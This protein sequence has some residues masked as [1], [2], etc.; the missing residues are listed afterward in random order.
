MRIAIFGHSLFHLAVGLNQNPS[1]YVQL[2][3]DSNTFPVTLKDEVSLHTQSFVQ[4]IGPIT[5][6]DLLHPKSAEITERLSGFDVALV[7]DLGPIFAASASIEFIFIPGGSD[8]TEYPFPFRSKS[9]RSRGRQDIVSLT[10]AARLRPAIRSA[11]G[12]W[13]SGPFSPWVLAA[14]RLGL[15]LDRFL[16]RAFDTR[17]FS[18]V[19]DNS[20][21]IEDSESLTIFHP[22]RI[23]YRDRL[24]TLET[25]GCKRNDVLFLGFAKAI[26][27]G[28]DTRLILIERDGSP[29]Q[30]KAK[31]LLSSLGVAEKVEWLQPSDPAGYSWHETAKLY[32]SSDIVVSDFAGW[33]GMVNVE[34]AACSRPVIG[35]LE[36][37]AM[38]SMYPGGHPVVEADSA[39]AVFEAI[40]RLAD[41]E[42]RKQIGIA[43]RQWALKYHDLNVVARRCE[44]MLV[45]LGVPN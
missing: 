35:H 29:D 42:E 15:S 20:R 24:R 41:P 38:M 26:H 11:L 36:S 12:I 37:R 27:A 43:S 32:R 39:F 34:G 2:F 31:E 9:T 17:L 22:T 3:I 25:A 45:A 10:V 8:F 5:Y 4:I 14:N 30:E 19:G 44:T 16:P 33:T 6:M 7:T 28:I 13:G 23:D 18:P 1:N 40:G 21:L